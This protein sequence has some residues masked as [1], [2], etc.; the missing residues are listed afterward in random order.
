MNPDLQ[1][2]AVTLF[3]AVTGN[4]QATWET[5]S[6]EE[7]QDATAWAHLSDEH[8]GALGYAQPA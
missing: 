1:R 6:D 7:R 3:R 4:D 2:L 8:Y 5:M